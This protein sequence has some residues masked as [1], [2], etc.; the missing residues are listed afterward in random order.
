M[1]LFMG[2][3][4]DPFNRGPASIPGGG[5]SG[6]ASEGDASAYAST[7]NAGADARRLC[8]VHQGARRLLPSSSAGAYG[9]RA[10][11][12]RRP[13]MA[14]QRSA[15]TTRPR[16]STAR[17]WALT[18]ASRRSRL[19]VLRWPAAAP[20]SVSP[21]AAP[22][23]P[24]CSRPAPSS[25]TRLV[26]LY[27]GRTRLWLAGHHHQPHRHC[28]RIRSTARAVRRQCIFGTSRRRL[29]LC[30]AVGRRHRHHALCRSAVHDVRSAWLCRAGH[31]RLQCF[32]AGL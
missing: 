2:T 10:S 13:P 1:N 6:Y 22:G 20:I 31:C 21:A 14:M 3:M 4:T 26:R 17:P 19:R 30:R 7:K 11:A 28:R 12:A 29:S 32:C 27:L 25:G 18:I 24:I 5:A 23:I 8:D 15:R 9:R 16:A